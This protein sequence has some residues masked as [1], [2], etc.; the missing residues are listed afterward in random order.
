MGILR[1]STC[2]GLLG[3]VWGTY[4]DSPHIPRAFHRCMSCGLLVSSDRN[5]NHKQ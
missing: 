3:L 1:C 4:A 5:I 2:R